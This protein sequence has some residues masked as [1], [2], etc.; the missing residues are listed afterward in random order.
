M[1]L[2]DDVGKV[3]YTTLTVSFDFRQHVTRVKY[4]AFGCYLLSYSSEITSV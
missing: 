2:C 1:V 4:T 3:L